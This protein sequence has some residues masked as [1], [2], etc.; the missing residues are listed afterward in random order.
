M[1]VVDD[2]VVEIVPHPTDPD[3]SPLLEG[4]IGAA[5]HRTRVLRPAIRRGWLEHGPGPTSDRGR[6][7]FVEVDWD[8]AIEA[9][10]S[11]IDRVRTQHGNESIFGGSYG[12]ASA[13]IFHHAQTQMKRMLNLA[14]GYTSSINSYSNGTSVVILPHIVGS[15]EEVLRRPTSWPT[16]VANTDLIVAFGGVPAKNVFVTPGGMTQ[17]HTR[18][19]L[20]S[21]AARGVE[22]ALVSPVRNDLSPGLPATWYP[23]VPGSDVAMMLGLAH[24]LFV[25][26]LADR[27]FL[28]RYTV[29]ADVFERYVLGTDDGV[30]KDAEWASA[31]CEIPA[32]SIRQLARHMAEV[33][34]LVTVTWSLQRI[35]H[36]EQPVWAGVALAALLGQ[37]GLPG[38]GFGHGYGSMGDVGSTGPAVGLPTFSKG[39]NPVK[40]FIPVAR[41]ADML[42]SPGQQFAYDGGTYSYPDIRLVYWAGGNPFHHHQHLDRLRTALGRPDTVVVNEPYWTA[43]ARHADI[44]L[45]TTIPMEREDMGAGRRDTHLIAMHRATS[46]PG[47]ALDDHEICRRIAERLDVA[48]AFTE[49]RTPRQWLEHIYNRWRTRI[50][51]VVPEFD[52]FWAQ[53]GIELPFAGEERTM[54]EQYRADPVQ[55]ALKTPSGRIELASDVVAGFGYDDC[56]G[57]PAWFEPDDAA[58]YPMHLIANQPSTRLHGQLDVGAASLGSKVRDREP[59]L[60]NPADATARGIADGDVVRVFSSRGACLAGAVVSTAVRP[61]VVQLATG[62]WYDPVD[63]DGTPTCVHGNPNAVTEDRPTSSLSQGCAGQQARVEV[64]LFTGPLPPIRVHHPPTIV[65]RAPADVA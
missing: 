29:G 58:G 57:H 45:P 11:E 59:I 19:H 23:V 42:L 30:V 48:D 33:R 54:F 56:P 15:S 63:F 41:I 47:Q 16:I 6:E 51:D 1:R 31:R 10:A 43:M 34:T 44:V 12:W 27:D 52:E 62:A 38:G 32:D 35:P 26:N 37:I 60:I 5:R 28:A 20:A 18:D 21:A 8:E 9:V 4:V 3:P 22:F 64:E 13:G 46:A 40:S 24:T 39:P 7:D 65:S 49:G 17:H 61:G 2:E 53:G 25:E 36:G 14:G 55:H 50:G